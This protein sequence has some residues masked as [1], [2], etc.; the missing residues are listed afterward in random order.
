MEG[1]TG[2]SGSG[3]DLVL[4]EV[5]LVVG[6]PSTTNGWPARYVLQI[7]WPLTTVTH[8]R[9]KAVFILK[10]ASPTLNMKLLLLFLPSSLLADSVDHLRGEEVN[11]ARKFPYIALVSGSTKGEYSIL[12]LN[13][14]L[15]SL[16]NPRCLPLKL[17]D[18][19]Q[20]S[21][22]WLS[23]HHSSAMKRWELIYSLSAQY[24]SH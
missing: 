16:S 7:R 11:S 5:L 12:P 20:A 23:N 13:L 9:T 17:K 6:F 18:C 22:G 19:H 3:G 14:A 24:I 1:L 10:V 2:S 4:K 21:R 8:T 15:Y